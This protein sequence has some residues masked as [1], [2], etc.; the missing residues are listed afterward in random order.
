MFL[1]LKLPWQ[2]PASILLSTYRIFVVAVTVSKAV[3][4]CVSV[5]LPCPPTHTLP[6][7]YILDINFLQRI[8]IH[9]GTESKD[10]CDVKEP[11]FFARTACL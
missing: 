8:K 4:P 6:V 2:I 3:L 9:I 10:S 5:S 11:S 1:F 7:F